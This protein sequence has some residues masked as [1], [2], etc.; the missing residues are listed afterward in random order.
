MLYFYKKIEEMPDAVGEIMRKIRVTRNYSQEYVAER[1]G[2][3]MTTYSRYERGDT[4]P[5]FDTIVV[6][7]ELYGLSL[8]EFYHFGEAKTQVDEPLESYQRRLKQTE[9]LVRLDGSENTLQRWVQKL[10]AINQ[11]L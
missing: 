6:L 3:D 10:T 9:I 7:C 4:Q 11:V 8:D 2:V 5:K 1:A